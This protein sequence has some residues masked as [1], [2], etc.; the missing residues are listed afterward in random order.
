MMGEGEGEERGCG[1]A[2]GVGSSMAAQGDSTCF[3]MSTPFSFSQKKPLRAKKAF[4][5]R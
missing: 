3:T 5:G 4:G 2:C 1:R